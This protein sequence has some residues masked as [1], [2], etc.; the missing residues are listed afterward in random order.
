MRRALVRFHRLV[1]PLREPVTALM[2]RE[3]HALAS[4]LYPYY[5][6]VYDHILRVNGS[7]DARRDL[8]STLVET[9]LSLSDFRQNQ[10]M[11]KVTRWAAIAV[12][13]LL[14]G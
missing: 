6:D 2:R 4:E 10:S 8:V 5:Q 12:P 3:Q 1:V 7:A 11:K 14:T 9:N 13:T